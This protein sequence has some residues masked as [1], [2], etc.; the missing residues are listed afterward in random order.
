[1]HE[2]SWSNRV[3]DSEEPLWMSTWPSLVQ[4]APA[5]VRARR[6][7]QKLWLDA[8]LCFCKNETDELAWG[9]QDSLFWPNAV[10]LTEN[11]DQGVAS[12]SLHKRPYAAHWHPEYM[13]AMIQSVPAPRH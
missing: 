1:M 11:P 12:R 6:I 3:E 8:C 10:H 7:Q 9:C 4:A 2:T 5:N 13:A